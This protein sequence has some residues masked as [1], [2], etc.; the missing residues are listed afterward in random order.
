MRASTLARGPHKV[1]YTSPY[2]LPVPCAQRWDLK[3]AKARLWQ[4]SID[5]ERRGAWQLEDDRHMSPEFESFIGRPMRGM[6]PG[7]DSIS[8]PE[9]RFR[10][11]LQ[12]Q[13]ALELHSRRDVP[14]QQNIMFGKDLYDQTMYGTSVPY[15]W[16]MFKE[17]TKAARNDR[18]TAQ[19]KFRVLQGS[20]QKRQP[21]NYTPIPDATD[22]DDE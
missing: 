7:A 1:G 11:R 13:T 5:T 22:D 6:R 2:A 9:V 3:L 4:E 17:M 14:F 15:T 20:G 19:N 21:A 18:K 16:H 12:N 10:Q 8:R